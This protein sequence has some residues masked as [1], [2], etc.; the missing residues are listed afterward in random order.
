MRFLTAY[1]STK[2][3]EW[4]LT[5][6]ERMKERPVGELVT[7]LRTL[8]ADITYLEKENYPPLNQA[9]KYSADRKQ[10]S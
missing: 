9:L 8:G 6:S 10:L 5:G 3:G 1:L 7:A 4:V 2:K